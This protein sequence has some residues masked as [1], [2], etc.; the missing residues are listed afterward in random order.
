MNKIALFGTSADPPTA[1]HQTIISWLGDNYDRV[2][3]WAS[4]NP[5]KCHQTSLKQREAMLRLLIEDI[6]P[7]KSNI[8]VYPEL[9]HTRTWNT[10]EQVQ[11]TWAEAELTLVVG[12]DLIL[13]L[14]RWYLAAK[15]LKEVNLLIVPRPGNPIR[16]DALAKLKEMGARVAIAPSFTP[17]VSSTAYRKFQD[18]EALTT[19]VKDYIDREQ[20]Y[21]CHN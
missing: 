9:S 13:Q 11:E 18:T 7:P 16:E 1:A 5:F 2:L 15:L 8:G 6:D 17:D 20:L 21:I 14:P 10:I 4:D 3:V 19:T 12:S